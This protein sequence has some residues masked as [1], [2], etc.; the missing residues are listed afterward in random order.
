MRIEK[1]VD[2]YVCMYVKVLS[3]AT[4]NQYPPGHREVWM[5]GGQETVFCWVPA[6]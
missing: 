6:P 2:K 4:V 1:S 3:L 5:V